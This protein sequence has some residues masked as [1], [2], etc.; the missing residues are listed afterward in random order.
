MEPQNAVHRARFC[1]LFTPVGIFKMPPGTLLQEN[2]GRRRAF[3]LSTGRTSGN[4]HGFA[5]D[6]Q[7]CY[8]KTRK[9]HLLFDCKCFIFNLFVSAPLTGEILN[10]WED[11]RKVVKFIDDN[12]NW[13]KP[14]MSVCEKIKR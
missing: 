9:K 14:L 13:L 2:R 7:N 8:F 1:W 12:A 11:F 6:T 5:I 3:H 4:Q 10:L